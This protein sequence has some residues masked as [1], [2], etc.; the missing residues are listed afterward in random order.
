MR[1]DFKISSN[2][3][4]FLL[5]VEVASQLPTTPSVEKRIQNSENKLLFFSNFAI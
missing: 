3:I 1:R 2:Q 5:E 4:I